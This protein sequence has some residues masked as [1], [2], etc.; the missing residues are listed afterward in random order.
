MALRELPKVER[1]DLAVVTLP[2]GHPSGDLSGD[3]SVPV[4][5]FL[6]DHPDGAI[7][8]D[9]GVGEGNAFI[10]DAHRPVRADLGEALGALGAELSDVVIVAANVD[11]DDDLRK[12][13]VESIRRLK[14]LRPRAIHLSHCPLHHRVS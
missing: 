4:Y 5:G 3:L 10:D 9:T 14:A 1:L 11:P 2:D 13:A 7:V 12:A 6:I 8:V